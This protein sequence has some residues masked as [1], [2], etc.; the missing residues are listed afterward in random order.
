MKSID[1]ANKLSI[2]IALMFNK[3]VSPDDIPTT[4]ITEITVER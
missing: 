2:L 1:A 3:Y 4:G